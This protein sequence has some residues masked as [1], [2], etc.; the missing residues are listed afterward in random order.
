MKNLI[1]LLTLILGI[2]QSHTLFSRD[3]FLLPKSKKATEEDPVSYFSALEQAVNKTF[4][5]KVTMA[6]SYHSLK[7]DKL[8]RHSSGFSP[9]GGLSISY[10]FMPY[11]SLHSGYSFHYYPYRELEYSK[12]PAESFTDTS[13]STHDAFFG[14]DLFLIKKLAIRIQL[15]YVHSELSF[16]TNTPHTASIKS[17]SSYISIYMI[18]SPKLYFQYQYQTASFLP[19]NDSLNPYRFIIPTPYF[20]ALSLSYSFEDA[21]HSQFYL[22]HRRSYYD[23]QGLGQEPGY[24][25]RMSH[26]FRFYSRPLNLIYGAGYSPSPYSREG[27]A[28]P[29]YVKASLTL[30]SFKLSS[31]YTHY[32]NNFSHLY[33]PPQ[34]N[35]LSDRDSAILSVDYLF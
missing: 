19:E 2:I 23:H 5:G 20:F 35:Q 13:L 26:R 17:L 28:L 21:Y 34:K 31:G 15:S 9:Q 7:D 24:N 8:Y 3:I 32:I 18:L 25:F 11:L 10:S 27:Y 16:T 33:I 22:S 1:F 14:L 4:T 30:G 29:V 12:S 6:L